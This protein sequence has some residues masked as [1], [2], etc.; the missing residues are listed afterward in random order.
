MHCWCIWV[1][2]EQYLID[3]AQLQLHILV[4]KQ[5]YIQKVLLFVAHFGLEASLNHHFGW[6]W[7]WSSN[8]F[9][10]TCQICPFHK[11]VHHAIQPVKILNY[12]R[13]HFLIV[14]SLVSVM[15]VGSYIVWLCIWSQRSMSTSTHPKIK[16]Q[17]NMQLC[18]IV[19]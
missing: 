16:I 5:I 6:K 9:Y 18:E 8:D 14:N 13:I 17:P 3:E 11:T 15:R 10:A 7:V 1:F 4:V 19:M 2:F 12:C